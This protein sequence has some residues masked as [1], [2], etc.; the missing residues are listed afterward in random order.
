V[1]E[2]HPG[3]RLAMGDITRIGLA[4]DVV[5]VRPGVLV[6][7]LGA[8]GMGVPSAHYNLQ[9]LY[10]AYSAATPEADTVAL[11]LR[12]NGEPVGW[13]GRQGLRYASSDADRR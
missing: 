12:R 8:G 10:L 11:E 9:R 3:L 2:Q 1:L 13:F 6:L 7:H 4:E 5:E